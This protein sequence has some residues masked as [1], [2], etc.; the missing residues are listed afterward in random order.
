MTIWLDAHFS[1][2]IARWMTDHF[3]VTA[4]PLR[5]LGLREAEDDAIWEAARK[6]GVV[7]MTK[8]A[9]FEAR[10]RRL[11]PPPHVLWFTCGNTTEARL[12]EMLAA[13]LEIALELIRAGESLVEIR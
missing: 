7:M 8:D 13:D 4:I 9:D 11:G 12:K 6:A 5:D 3:A 2:R 1:P 10:V